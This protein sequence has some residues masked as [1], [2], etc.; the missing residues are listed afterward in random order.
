M[1]ADKIV[2]NASPLILLCN[3]DLAFI[4][5]EL[6]TEIVLP[7]AVWQEILSSPHVDKA[8]QTLPD[9]D[10]LQKIPVTNS[11]DVIRWDVGDGETEVLSFAFMHS[12][13]T[14]V[15]DDMAAKKCAVSLSIPTLGTGSMLIMAKKRG[16]IGSVERSLR[17][18]QQLGLWISEAVIALLKERAGE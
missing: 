14:A 13:Y 3:G 11:A 12:A 18:L 16:L 15:V 17:T 4:L 1:L 2:I 10:W 9:L 8:A 5:P 7:E 6:F